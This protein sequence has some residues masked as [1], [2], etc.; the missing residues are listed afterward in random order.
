MARI[1]NS[2][3]RSRGEE[4]LARLVESTLT[5]I[6]DHVVV[7]M[8]ENLDAHFAKM[9]VG[10]QRRWRAF[11]Q[12]NPRFVTV[13]TAQR[14]FDGVTKQDM[15][16]Y[17]VLSNVNKGLTTSVAPSRVPTENSARV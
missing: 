17:A 10:E 7:L 15:P 3:S 6:G 5:G 4:A 12:D 2:S 8:I 14:L 1:P 9:Q 11:I 13:A 16:F